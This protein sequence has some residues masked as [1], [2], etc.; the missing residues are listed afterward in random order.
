MFNTFVTSISDNVILW[1]NITLLFLVSLSFLSD[2][3]EFL[4]GSRLKQTLTN[5]RNFL[6]GIYNVFLMVNVYRD[7]IKKQMI[8]SI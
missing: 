3:L 6:I 8:K 1:I 7:Y 2:N 4:L 5:N